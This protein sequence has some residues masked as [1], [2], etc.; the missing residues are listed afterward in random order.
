MLIFRLKVILGT[1]SSGHIID[2]EKYGKFALDIARF[3]VELYRWRPI[4]PTMHKI[5]IHGVVITKNALLPIWQLSE[6]AAEWRNKQF[7]SYRRNFA[8]KLS[9]ES[10]NKDIFNRLPLTSDPRMSSLRSVNRP[11][12]TYFLPE[13][14]SLLMPAT[15]IIADESSGTDDENII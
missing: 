12:F 1:I 11:R 8:R 6:E 2:T 14:I 9:R 15:P 3:Y 13:T 10:C 7:R 4:S 5:L